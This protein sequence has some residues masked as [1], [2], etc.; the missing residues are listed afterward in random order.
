MLYDVPSSRYETKPQKRLFYCQVRVEVINIEDNECYKN[1]KKIGA[2]VEGWVD[3]FPADN[4]ASTSTGVAG[5]I[6]TTL[7]LVKLA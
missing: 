1:Y 4:K 5:L 2:T 3:E 7:A 6:M